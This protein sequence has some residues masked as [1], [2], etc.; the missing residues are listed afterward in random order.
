MG[1][2]PLAMAAA[3][4]GSADHETQKPAG[5]P[6]S[7]SGEDSG[8]LAPTLVSSHGVHRIASGPRYDVLQAAVAYLRDKGEF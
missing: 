8:R 7:D 2:A 1:G 5:S 6:V 4:V 3:P